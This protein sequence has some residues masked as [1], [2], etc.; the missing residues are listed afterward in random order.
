MP[1][2]PETKMTTQE[3]IS[4][5]QAFLDGKLIQFKYKSNIEWFNCST[6]VWNFEDNDYRI[7][8]ES[9]KPEALKT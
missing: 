6:P 2:K 1:E 4:A 9:S 8:P 5:L 7:K 3:K